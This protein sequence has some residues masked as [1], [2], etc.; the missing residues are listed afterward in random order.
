MSNWIVSINRDG[1]LPSYRVYPCMGETTEM[2]EAKRRLIEA[3]P[4]LLEAC[5][6]ALKELDDYIRSITPP[7]G[8][9]EELSRL[10]ILKEAIERA[11]GRK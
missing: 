7:S 6:W 2:I 8:L 9:I 10:Q 3:A 5:K 4:D 11:E 1:D